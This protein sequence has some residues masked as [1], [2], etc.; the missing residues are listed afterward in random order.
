M[1]ETLNNQYSIEN[2]TKQ[3]KTLYYGNPFDI[4]N[5]IQSDLGTPYGT[6]YKL[7]YTVKTDG[8][9]IG[10][11]L[12][13]VDIDKYMIVFTVEDYF[14]QFHLTSISDYIISSFIVK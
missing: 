14:N 11:V 3:Y 8:S 4:K 2:I 6:A 12:Y 7:Q 13:G 1:K 10:E 5:F 9:T